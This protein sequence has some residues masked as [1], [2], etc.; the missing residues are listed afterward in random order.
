MSSKQLFNGER[1]PKAD[2]VFEALGH[3]DELNVLLGMAREFGKKSSGA[4]A[5]NDM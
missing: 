3:Q 2:P 4:I 5:L 1:R